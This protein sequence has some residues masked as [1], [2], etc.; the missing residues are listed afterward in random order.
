MKP[1]RKEHLA[2]VFLFGELKFII[3]EF[4]M[5]NCFEVGNYLLE[6]WKGKREEDLR[7]DLWGKCQGGTFE[8]PKI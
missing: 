3:N 2:F 4:L 7:V 6:W 8:C 1:Q 5:E